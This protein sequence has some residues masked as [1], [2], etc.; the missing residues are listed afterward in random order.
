MPALAPVPYDTD[1]SVVPENALRVLL[2]GYGPFFRYRENPCWLAVKPL[3]NTILTID[4]PSNRLTEDD[5]DLDHPNGYAQ[6]EPQHIHITTL[7]LP[8]T[9]QAVFDTV[10]GF[11]T[12]PPTLPSDPSWPLAPPPEAGYDFIFHIGL[13]GRGPFRMERLGHKHGYRIKDTTGQHAP[14]ID[15]LPDATALEQSQ[16]EMLEQLASASIARTESTVATLDV[17]IEAPLRGFS[18]GYETYPEEIYTP[19]D[20]EKLVHEM[21]AMGV[22]SIYSSMDAGHY[23]CDFT[24]YCS[25]AE[26][27]RT[28][29]KHDKGKH[30]KVLF[31]HCPPIDQPFS[32]EEVTDAIQKI[33]MW[34]CRGERR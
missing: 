27:R 3:N 30:T 14:T 21:K 2:T 33:V 32:T 17:A 31:M 23:V 26:A 4:P 8:V 19:I 34:V 5:L 11:H 1:G 10:P 24:Y 12:R 25:L 13:A 18:K 7:Q 29:L 15:R 9:Y 6:D 28:S 20:V 22:E 16:A